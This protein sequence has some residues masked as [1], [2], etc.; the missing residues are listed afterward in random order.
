MDI[1]SFVQTLQGKS[2]AIFGLGLSNMAVIRALAAHNVRVYAWDD[3]PA[4]FEGAAAAGAIVAELDADVLAQ[5]AVL[6]LAPGVNFTVDP[7]PVVVRARD[8]GLEIICDI[9]IFYR[10]RPE[11][12]RIVAITGTNGK[13]TTSALTGHIFN[14]CGQRAHVAGN[15]GRPVLDLDGI[16]AG[17]VVVLELSS[18]QLDLCPQ[19]SADIAVLMNI[20]PD[21][22]DRHGTMDEYVNA[23]RRILNDT[24]DAVIAIDDPLSKA[25]AIEAAQKGARKV[26]MVSVGG[27][28]EGGVYMQDGALIDDMD[29]E[30]AEIFRPLVATL[31]GVH[32]QQNILVAYNIARL[33]GI[34]P[35]AIAEAVKTYPGLPHR[36]F[37]VRIINGMPYINDSKATNADAAAR[38]LSC[39]RKIYWIAG[40]RMKEGGL[41]GLDMYM[42][43]IRHVFLIGE[44]AEHFADWLD[45]RG[46]PHTIS[47]TLERAVE[48]AH[49]LAQ[50]ERGEPGG[51]GTVLL[52]PACASFDQFQNFEDRGDLFTRCVNALPEEEGA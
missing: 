42:D 49:D 50:A 6:V 4:K 52:S 12:C 24:G 27:P 36:Q 10:A 3:A 15:I 17:D 48:D 25:L 11:A 22:L 41:D 43:R 23:K 44:A 5:C 18:F 29:G 14:Q 30:G 9:E 26:H 13:S 34:A 28:I 35:S 31:P 20:T 1:G 8:A 21:H 37:L 51:M 38:A 33:F 46:V 2:V 7:H 16:G 47:R 32:N 19:F 45:K 40:G 39:Y